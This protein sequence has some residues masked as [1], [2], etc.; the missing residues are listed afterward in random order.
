VL[1][2]PRVPQS[3]RVPRAY[4]LVSPAPVEVPGKMA[5]PPRWTKVEFPGLAEGEDDQHTLAGGGRLVL[6]ASW[7]PPHPGAYI[8]QGVWNDYGGAI[9]EAPD[10]LPIMPLRGDDEPPP[11]G[12]AYPVR[13]AAFSTYAS[14]VVEPPKPA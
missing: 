4:L 12:A 3:P 2:D 9:R 8:V 5:V 7:L 11:R 6:A 13:G 1:T 14:F 10:H